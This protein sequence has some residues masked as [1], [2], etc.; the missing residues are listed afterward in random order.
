MRS[1]E[2][3]TRID[4]TAIAAVLDLIAH[5]EVVDGYRPASDQF[6]IDLHHDSN[7][8]VI[9]ARVL[10]SGSTVAYAQA[11]LSAGRWSMESIVHPDHRE[12]LADTLRPLLDAVTQAIRSRTTAA[13]LEL[14]WLVFAPSKQHTDVAANMNLLAHRRLYQMYR[15]LPT[16]VTFDVT[17][18]P[19]EPGVDDLDWLRVNQ[20]AFEW[21]PDQGS[22]THESLRARIAEPWFDADGFLIHERDGRMAGFCWTKVHVLSPSP[23]GEI[24]VIAVDPDFHGLGL[25]RALTLAG[26]DHLARSGITMGMLFVDADNTAA[27][28]LYDSLGFSVHRTD[29]LYQGTLVRGHNRGTT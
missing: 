24:Y 25:G 17:T 9:R 22:W 16:N 3:S 13:A 10:D 26:L 15:S 27:V 29:C 20:R 4:A 1:V 7:R 28:N 2:V 6:M 5:A 18:R 12:H 11:A 14:S 21:N 8:D 19:F 23:L